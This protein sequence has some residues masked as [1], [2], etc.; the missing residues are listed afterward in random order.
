MCP[1]RNGFGNVAGI[2]DAAIGND[3]YTSSFQRFG[4]SENCRDLRNS[5][6][7]NNPRGAD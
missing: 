5:D 1:S 7:G 4:G 6:T 3:R 2:P